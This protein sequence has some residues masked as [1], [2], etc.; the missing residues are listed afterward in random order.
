MKQ[1]VLLPFW[2]NYN[3]QK[4]SIMYTTLSEA[5]HVQSRRWGSCPALGGLLSSFALDQW[6]FCH[7]L[8]VTQSTVHGIIG[9]NL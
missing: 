2:F 8:Q 9:I 6:R 1:K 4:K 3:L 5:S 7:V